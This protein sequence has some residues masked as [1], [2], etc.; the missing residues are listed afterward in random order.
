MVNLSFLVYFISVIF[1]KICQNM[2]TNSANAVKL[3]NLFHFASNPGKIFFSLRLYV[4]ALFEKSEL[5]ANWIINQHQ[6]TSVL[7]HIHKRFLNFLK[8]SDGILMY[9]LPLPS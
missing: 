6:F 8:T 4:T 2:T 7:G 3:G 1:L 5:I 9:S